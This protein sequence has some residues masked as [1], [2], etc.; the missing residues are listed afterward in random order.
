[1]QLGAA[2]QLFPAWSAAATL[3]RD[4]A[5]AAAR[6]ASLAVNAGTSSERLDAAVRAM[7]SFDHAIDNANHLPVRWLVPGARRTYRGYDA[8]KHAVTL[9]VGSG[10]IPG[11]RERVGRQ[12]LAAARDAFASGVSVARA[13]RSRYARHL[14]AG[15]LEAATED[16][17]AGSLMLRRN[18][19]AAV[20]LLGSLNRL[21]SDFGQR[22]SIDEP[23]IDNVT[24]LFATIG[25]EMD[26]LVGVVDDPESSSPRSAAAAAA[27]QAADLL[28]TVARDAASLADAVAEPA[29]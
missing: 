23:V 18:A 9:L 6:Y 29:A 14:A 16:A 17:L 22:G 8:A 19:Q 7:T 4:H 21:R 5:A 13:D 12:Q 1:M 20:N 26:S 28:T 3:V 10:L 15:W 24:K 2:R 27:R 25:A 11:A